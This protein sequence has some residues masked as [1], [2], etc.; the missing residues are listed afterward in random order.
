MK[1]HVISNGDLTNPVETR[2]SSC[3]RDKIGLKP[4]LDSSRAR[5]NHTKNVGN[6]NDASCA[7]AVG[8]LSPPP[9][10]S[11]TCANHRMSSRISLAT[12]PVAGACRGAPCGASKRIRDRTRQKNS[13][14]HL[15]HCVAGSADRGE[16][17]HT[18][19][20]GE[21]HDRAGYGGMTGSRNN[22][23][24]ESRT[25]EGHAVGLYVDGRGHGAE[26]ACVVAGGGTDR[27]AGGQNATRSSGRLSRGWSMP[28]RTKSG[29]RSA[30]G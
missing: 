17:A 15:I 24:G 21:R 29:G 7:I 2:H 4:K 30:N 14:A 11:I 19:P 9:H 13:H 16:G 28:R 3:P 23:A 1:S 12:S 25:G 5:A 27:G 26:G 8:L 18:R 6:H 22:G 20:C 10:G